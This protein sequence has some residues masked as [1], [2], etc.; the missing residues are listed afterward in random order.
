MKRTKK[1]NFA[2]FILHL[3]GILTCVLPAVI[4]TL[5]YFPLWRAA[6][7]EYILA[8]GTALLIALAAL[9][10]YKYI[11]DALRS[12][13]SYV[14]WL[15]IFVFCFLLSKVI[16]QLTVISLVGFVSNLLGALLLKLGD[17]CEN[18]NG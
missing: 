5:C 9:P 18:M 1:P 3:I 2:K 10:F 6:G 17:R 7:A 14:L 13:A 4:C 12:A 11:R 16:D 15:I 8:G